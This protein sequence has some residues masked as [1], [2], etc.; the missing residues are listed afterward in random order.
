[1]VQEEAVVERKTRIVK[2]ERLALMQG[3]GNDDLSDAHIFKL[4]TYLT[5]ELFI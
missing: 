4:G 2:C 5:C 1:M 3:S